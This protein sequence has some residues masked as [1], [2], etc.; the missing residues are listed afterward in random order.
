MISD[1][2]ISHIDQLVPFI[3]NCSFGDF[4]TS[5]KV[6]LS[7]E[8]LIKEGFIFKYGIED[9]FDQIVDYLKSK[10]L[11]KNWNILPV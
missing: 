4:T 1:F 6:I 7:S 9:I 2:T 10:G 8:K 11:L 5:A 3:C